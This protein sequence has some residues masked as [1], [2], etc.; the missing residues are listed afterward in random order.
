MVVEYAKYIPVSVLARLVGENDKRLWTIINH[1]VKTARNQVDM[2]KVEIIGID[3]TSEKRH[4][5]ITIVV[6]LKTHKVLF[7]TDGKDSTTVDAFVKDFETHRGD[8]DN[9]KIITCDMSLGF[10][11]GIKSNFLNAESIIDKFLSCS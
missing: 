11:K 9:I 7:V 8:P 3:E 10:E 6:D 1:Y 5:Y 2:S 4:H